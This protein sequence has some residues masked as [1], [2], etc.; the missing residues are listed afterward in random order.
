M[1]NTKVECRKHV[2]ISSHGSCSGGNLSY[3]GNC[4]NC[5]IELTM[6]GYIDK[7]NNGEAFVSSI[8]GTYKVHRIIKNGS[9]I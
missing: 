7:D 8:D 1:G 2:F 6:Y 3:H 9:V 5:G 4:K